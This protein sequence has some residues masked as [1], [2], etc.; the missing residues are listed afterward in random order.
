MTTRR[1]MAFFSKCSELIEKNTR[2]EKKNWNWT[3]CISK[4]WFNTDAITRRNSPSRAIRAFPYI[5]FW[6]LH[7]SW[8]RILET[9]CVSDNYKMLATVLYSKDHQYRNSVTNIH[10]VTNFKSLTS[11]SPILTRRKKQA[12]WCTYRATKFV[13]CCCSYFTQSMPSRSGDFIIP[14]T[15]V[16]VNIRIRRPNSIRFTWCPICVSRHLK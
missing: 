3:W 1:T 11:M 14:K 8:W 9:K 6:R 5:R 13:Q 2:S 10:F 12:Y 4:K 16:K 15:I 7:R